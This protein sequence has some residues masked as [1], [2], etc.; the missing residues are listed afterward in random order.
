MTTLY[1]G[2]FAKLNLTLDVGAKHHDGYHDVT[3]VMTSAA[4]HDMVTVESK[5][6]GGISLSCSDATLPCD[7]TNLAYRAAKLFFDHF[8]IECEGVH[9]HLEKHIPAQAGMAGGSTDAAATFLGLRDLYGLSVSDEELQ[10]LALPLG[11]DIPYCIAGG[12]K[13]AEG[14]GDTIRVSLTADPVEEVAAAK[15]ILRAVGI[16]GQ[17]GMDIV[18]CPTCSRTK[19]DLIPLVKRFEEAVDKAGLASVPV[20]VALMGCPVNGPGEAREADVGIAGGRGEAVLFRRGEIIEK[21]PEEQVIDR[22]LHEIR[23]L[24]KEMNA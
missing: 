7:A 13:L 16:E 18:S 6:D 19:I 20:K 15:Q 21:I 4:L 23:L 10:R 9:I 12:T 22:L 3:S 8:G 11:A 24:R 2:A 1:E 5:P 14:I 17:C